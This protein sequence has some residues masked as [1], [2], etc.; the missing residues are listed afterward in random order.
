MLDAPQ[1]DISWKFQSPIAEMI[2][3]ALTAQV[4]AVRPQLGLHRLRWQTHSLTG[5]M[6]AVLPDIAQA[7]PAALGDAYIRGHDMVASYDPSA[8]WPCTPQIYWR[9]EPSKQ[10]GGAL[11]SVSLLVSIQTNLLDTHPIVSAASRLPADEMLF[12]AIGGNDQ[13][14]V[15]SLAPGRHTIRSQMRCCGLLW[16]LSGGQFTYAE[17]ATASDFQKLTIEA[18]QSGVCEARWQLFVE[19]LEKGVI[20]RAQIHAAF[21]PRENDVAIAHGLCR[22]LESRPLP[23]TT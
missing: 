8:D 6:L 2:C 12:I 23:L 9:A 18:A 14:R 16:R 11:A 3:G 7:W 19:F 17:F 10:T 13:P 15:E 20:R 22:G 21:L 5:N 1:S 4:D